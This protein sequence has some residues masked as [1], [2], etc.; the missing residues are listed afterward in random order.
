MRQH[1]IWKVHAV[2]STSAPP[3]F[4]M[5]Q[6]W[7]DGQKQWQK[8]PHKCYCMQTKAGI[9]GEVFYPFEQFVQ[10]QAIHL[11][12]C[13]QWYERSVFF[14]VHCDANKFMAAASS[15]AERTGGVGFVTLYLCAHCAV[16]AY[17]LFVHSSLSA[18]VTSE[19]QSHPVFPLKGRWN[20]F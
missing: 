3:T 9:L 11:A 6:S 1:I 10:E 19:N 18:L 15:V 7:S 8:M 4:N 16:V 12:H 5:L 13:V 17:S 2:L 20:S 14:T